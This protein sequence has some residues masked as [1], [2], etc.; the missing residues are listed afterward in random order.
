GATWAGDVMAKLRDIPYPSS[1]DA[2]KPITDTATD[3]EVKDLGPWYG[4]EHW[5]KEKIATSVQRA[6][7]WA[8]SHNNAA[9]ICNE[10]GSYQLVAPRQS[11]LNFISDI[12]SV[13]E[14]KRIGWAMW[15]MD[16][17]FGFINYAGNDRNT[18]TT[19]DEL[20]HALGLK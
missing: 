7:D 18:F 20:L 12:R 6:V 2:V 19:D 4:S 11:R 17:G 10:F 15:E 3:T 8:A 5:N 9:I 1:P 14:E 16:E 13:F